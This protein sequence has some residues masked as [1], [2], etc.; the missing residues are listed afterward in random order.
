MSDTDAAVDGEGRRQILIKT[1]EPRTIRFIHQFCHSNHLWWETQESDRRQT[2][3]QRSGQTDQYSSMF[4]SIS[5]VESELMWLMHV[6]IALTQMS[7]IALN[8]SA[9]EQNDYSTKTSHAMPSST[10]TFNVTLHF[11]FILSETPAFS[12][13]F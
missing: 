6:N 5:V 11:E 9:S 7:L 13:S 4:S 3:G 2:E 8:I 10:H 12:G 1:I